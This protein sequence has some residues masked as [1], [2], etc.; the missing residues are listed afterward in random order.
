[1][2][3]QRL[4]KTV[5]SPYLLNHLSPWSSLLGD[6]AKY[7]PY[8]SSKGL[9]PFKEMEYQT[10][11]PTTSAKAATNVTPQI[12]IFPCKTANPAKGNITSLGILINIPTKTPK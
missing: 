12:V 9:P 5:K 7:L 10:K 8:L 1:M 6:I 3:M 4:I 11:A 2:G